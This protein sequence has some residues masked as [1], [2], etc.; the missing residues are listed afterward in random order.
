MQWARE[1]E[2]FTGLEVQV[3]QG[4]VDTRG[5]QYRNP[6]PFHVVNYELVVRDLPVINDTLR[7]DLLILDEAQRIK[8]WRTKIASAVKRV[9]SR[10]AFVLTDTPLEN[11][12][13]DLYSLMQ[14]IDSRVLGPLWR[15]LVD[16]HVT[17][18]RGKVL[19]YRNLSE[20]RRRLRYEER[21][22]GLVEGKRHLF[23]NVVDPEATEE[24][25]SVSRP[26]A[27]ILA[28]DLVAP[29]ATTRRLRSRP[30]CGS[31]GK[32]CRQARSTLPTARY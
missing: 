32:R 6:S 16:F 17:D 3:V 15:Y 12:L 14:V 30:A 4:P 29:A 5:A 20:L 2:K 19:G 13:E 31:T 23:D 26:L 21:V 27:E 11:R 8:N 24:V 28:S 25:V 22:L 7:P 9:Q 10:Y 1:I 18:D